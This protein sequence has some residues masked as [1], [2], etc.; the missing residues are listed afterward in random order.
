MRLT[1]LFPNRSIYFIVTM[2]LS[3]REEKG[4]KFCLEAVATL[5]QRVYGV[6]YWVVGEGPLR[7]Y[8]G[9]PGTLFG[10]LLLCSLL[11]GMMSDV[12][13]FTTSISTL[14]AF[15]LLLRLA[16]GDDKAWGRAPDAI[17]HTAV[18]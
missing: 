5:K 15:V 11:T 13:M 1:I 14:I 18:R 6:T 17:L 8:L 12:I 10:L 7:R 3:G 2:D 9:G 4:V 16:F